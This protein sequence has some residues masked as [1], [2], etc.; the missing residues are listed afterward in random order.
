MFL[1]LV[2]VSSIISVRRIY[3]NNN[4]ILSNLRGLL[5]NETSIIYTEYENREVTEYEN[6]IKLVIIL[7]IAIGCLIAII[8][9]IFLIKYLC[10]KCREKK[11]EEKEIQENNKIKTKKSKSD[12][13]SYEMS[14][15]SYN[16]RSL[17]RSSSKK[18]S[19]RSCGKIKNKKSCTSVSAL[20][21][22]KLDKRSKI[23]SN[24]SRNK[25][26]IICEKKYNYPE[27]KNHEYDYY[28]GN[29]NSFEDFNNYFDKEY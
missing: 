8:G 4:Y 13:R 9:S 7:G 22:K 5:L 10:K 2:L 24:G 11:E 20:E 19:S 1:N 17:K 26:N 3:S 18:K 29:N 15:I 12:R 27:K 21:D 25:N 28:F 6:H 14:N 23:K 16:R